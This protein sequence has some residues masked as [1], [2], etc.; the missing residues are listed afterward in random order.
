MAQAWWE[1]EDEVV[2]TT[3]NAAFGAELLMQKGIYH[4]H[5]GRPSENGYRFIWRNQ[6]RLQSRPAR[7][8]NLLE[9]E[10]LAKSG[11]DKGWK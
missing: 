2:S 7:I 9:V 3:F 5:D 10:A 8:D 6:G 4:F 1:T 11:R